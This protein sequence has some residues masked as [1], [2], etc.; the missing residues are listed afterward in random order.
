MRINDFKRALG[1]QAGCGVAQQA[2][3]REPS[4]SCVLGALT[5]CEEQIT[6]LMIMEILAMHRIREEVK[7]LR[8]RDDGFGVLPPES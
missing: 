4:L 6:G 8:V 5:C 7:V 2:E 3:C 1:S